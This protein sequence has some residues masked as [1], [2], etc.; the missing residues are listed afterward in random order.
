[1]LQEGG[2]AA[3]CGDSQVFPLLV[4]HHQLH[5]AAAQLLT[6]AIRGHGTT[7][8]PSQLPSGTRGRDRKASELVKN[9]HI[10]A[11][12]TL[13]HMDQ[14][15]QKTAFSG[16]LKPPKFRFISGAVTGH[17][18]ASLG[19]PEAPEDIFITDNLPNYLDV[20]RPRCQDP[21]E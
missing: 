18:P 20:E 21:T 7:L 16:F 11:F 6:Q 5:F 3:L 12:F 2:D 14:A 13:L 19:Q 4:H 9:C 10:Q 15:F 8:A 17:L 1:M